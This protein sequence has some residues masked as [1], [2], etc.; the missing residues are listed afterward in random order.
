MRVWPRVSQVWASKL[1][2]F[3]EK[4]REEDKGLLFPMSRRLILE[5]LVRVR[6]GLKLFRGMVGKNGRSLESRL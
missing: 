6:I 5:I 3:F 2:T 1:L 4:L